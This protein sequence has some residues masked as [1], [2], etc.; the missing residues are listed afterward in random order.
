MTPQTI[1]TRDEW[2][3]ARLELLEAEKELTRRSDEL[4]RRRQ[5]LPWVRIDKEYRFETDDGA[6][7]WRT[8][9]GGAR[10]CS[11]TTSCSG[12]ISPPAA[13]PAPRSRMASTAPSSISH[14]TTCRSARS[15]GHR[16]RSC[17]RTSGAW[18]GAS[19]GRRRAEATSTTTSRSARTEEEQRSGVVEYNYRTVDVGRRSQ[20]GKEGPLAEFAAGAGVDWA[21]FTREAPGVSAFALDD[22]VV[23]HTYSA[24]AR[25]L[26]GLWGMYQWLDRAPRGRNETGFWWRRHDEYDGG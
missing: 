8:F 2:L 16:S 7:R 1:G 24:Y 18:A 25:G 23:Y 15:R 13:H 22:G 17:R 12:P 11:S 21:T 5:E 14:T 20:A 4:A 6:P 3:A 19:R 10:S 26:D 9:S